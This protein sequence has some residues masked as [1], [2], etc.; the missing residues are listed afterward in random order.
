MKKKGLSDAE[1]IR[2]RKKFGENSLPV[3]GEV[4][5]FSIWFS[6][7]KSPLVYILVLVS[8]VSL[9]FKE[10]TNA[11]L[12]GVV[13]AINAVMG[14]FQEFSA[15]KT[16]KALRKVLKP[17]AFVIRE[18]IG[19]E[20]E[21]RELVP[22]D[23]V[24]LS[25]GDRI[26]ADGKLLESINFLANESI[27]TG[28]EEAVAKSQDA[29]KNILFMG[30]IVLA[31]KGVMEVQKTGL[32]TEI[33]K[34]GKSLS[35]I[36]KEETPLQIK[37]QQ[38]SKKLAFII[39]GI[40]ALIFLIGIL[41]GQDPVSMLK[42]S[43]ILSVAAIPEGLPI[44]ITVIL[45]LGMKRILKRNGLVKK[46]L[47]IE[48]LGSTS[49]ICTDKTGT[50]TEGIMK[51]ERIDFNDMEKALFGL[52]VTNDQRDAM[53]LAIWEYVK[54]EGKF[55]PHEVLEMAGRKYEEIFDSEKKY[56]LAII[57]NGSKEE[58]FIK[59]APEIILSFCSI[60][61]NEK[62]AVLE[63]IEKWAG[64]GLRVLGVIYK[65]KGELK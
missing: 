34:I 60:S 30:T 41:Y 1:V 19:K 50:L 18:G 12:I 51:V 11:I 47:S 29:D 63:K 13:I 38:F 54:K 58:S 35:E 17:T 53:E 52:T 16:L 6:Q 7:F 27:L 26:P 59:G 57:G 33:G 45:T 61:E 4:S 43:I 55:N 40:C 24:L 3:K 65:E 56:S 64:D 5:L 42:I 21:V 37:L 36:Q 9:F 2:L 48:T 14:F 31:G 62:K 20:V 28:E 23:I 49:V 25:P 10:Y 44:V 39:L 32:E 15:Q 46:L 22:G 8:L